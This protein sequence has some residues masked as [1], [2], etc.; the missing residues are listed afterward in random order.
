MMTSTERAYPLRVKSAI[1]TLHRYFRSFPMS[2]QFPSR[3]AF[4]KRA[5]GGSDPNSRRRETAI[6]RHIENGAVRPLRCLRGVAAAPVPPHF[7]CRGRARRVPSE[8]G[9]DH[10]NL[11]H[12]CRRHLCPDRTSAVD[13]DCD[14]VVRHLE[15][16]RCAV[17]GE[18]DCRHRGG[19]V[20]LR[21]LPRRRAQ[22]KAGRARPGRS[23]FPTRGHRAVVLYRDSGLVKYM[24][25]DPTARIV[26]CPGIIPA[27][28]PRGSTRLPILL[29]GFPGAA[30]PMP[31]RAGLAIAQT[32]I[33]SVYGRWALAD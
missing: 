12:A 26:I 16:R 20:E 7:G 5:K 32:L 23:H 31:T 18:L 22:L 30:R 6:V 4:L 27:G 24:L 28:V 9:N 13:P 10:K 33:A 21:R 17:L 14:G 2:R 29:C 8:T 15:W 3:S 25:C 19:R 1:L 11:L